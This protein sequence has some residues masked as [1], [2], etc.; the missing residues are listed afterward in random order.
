MTASQPST[1][2]PVSAEKIAKRSGFS[3][4]VYPRPEY[5][6]SS[7]IL[8]NA[9]V[10]KIREPV[11]VAALTILFYPYYLAAANAWL[12]RGGSERG[13]FVAGTVLVHFVLYF[14]IN[15]AFQFFDYMGWFEQ[16]KLDRTPGMIPKTK[17]ILGTIRDAL[18][19]QLALGPLGAWFLI[20]PAFQYFGSPSITAPLPSFSSLWCQY[21]FCSFVNDWGFYWSHRL[22]HSSWLY[23]NIH[24]KHHNYVGS[25]GFAAEHAHPIEQIF[26]NTL[27]SIGG[28]MLAGVHPWVFW[29]WLTTRLQQTY[30]AHSGYC[31]AGTWLHKIGLTRADSAAFHDFH[32][33]NNTGN[34]GATYLDHFFGTMDSWREI[35]GAEGYIAQKFSKEK[36]S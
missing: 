23:R 5:A 16:Y 14:G 3:P 22:F 21:V 32:H 8:F 27:P 11:L 12:G 30:E 19:G 17:Q 6:S 15:G 29:C 35:G 4:R 9:A 18:I 7:K 28:C 31:F 10:C 26:A 2:A 34:F 1:K 13:F 25:I 36:R 20:Y 33:S 24:K